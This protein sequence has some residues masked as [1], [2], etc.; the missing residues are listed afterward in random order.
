MTDDSV[1]EHVQFWP[2]AII[3]TD[4]VDRISVNYTIEF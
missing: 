2:R 4:E 1:N 3:K